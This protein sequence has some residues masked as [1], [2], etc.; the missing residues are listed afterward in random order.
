MKNY[1]FDTIINFILFLYI[2]SLYIFTFDEGL[3]VISNIIAGMFVVSV[4]VRI[5]LLTRK[6]Y[7]N[8]FIIVFFIFIAICLIS[9]FYAVNQELVFIKVQTLFLIFIFIF[10]FINYIDTQEKFLKVIN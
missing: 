1:R 10:F 2:L 7:V 5:L 6:I 4:V 3:H 8:S 9:G